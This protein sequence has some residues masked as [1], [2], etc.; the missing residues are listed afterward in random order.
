MCVLETDLYSVKLTLHYTL[1]TVVLFGRQTVGGSSLQTLSGTDADSGLK[2]ACSFE[3]SE[4]NV[5]YSL[6]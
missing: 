4:Q 6:I 2:A 5:Y 1:K 3:S